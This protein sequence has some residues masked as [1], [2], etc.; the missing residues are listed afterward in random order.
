MNH[1]EALN[2]SPQ[3]MD[4]IVYDV[5]QT[6]FCFHN[7]IKLYPGDINTKSLQYSPLLKKL[8]NSENDLCSE[9]TKVYVESLEF[10]LSNKVFRYRKPKPT[11]TS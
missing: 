1:L 9:K 2:L 6:I 7:E 11:F 4:K 3:E 8:V 10:V 5:A